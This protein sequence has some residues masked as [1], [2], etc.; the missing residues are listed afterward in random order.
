MKT[1][2]DVKRFLMFQSLFL[3]NSPSKSELQ[4]TN[5]HS[6]RVSILVFV[7]LALEVPLSISFLEFF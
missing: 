5:N 7:E 2:I 4:E 1:E 3:W 6:G